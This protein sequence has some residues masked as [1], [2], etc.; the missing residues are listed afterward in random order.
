MAGDGRRCC[1]GAPAGASRDGLR[2]AMSHFDLSML[3]VRAP[4]P[5]NGLVRTQTHRSASCAKRHNFSSHAHRQAPPQDHAAVQALCC[6]DRIRCGSTAGI[7][8]REIWT[9]ITGACLEEQTACCCSALPREPLTMP[10][11]LANKSLKGLSRDGHRSLSIRAPSTCCS[12]PLQR[13]PLTSQV[14]HPPRAALQC[15]PCCRRSTHAP[16]CS[17]CHC[18]SWRSCAAATIEGAAVGAA[19]VLQLRG[20]LL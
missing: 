13:V 5:A 10:L 9:H 6:P 18:L 20:E 12:L 2:H 7:A 11:Y 14:R 17:L 1:A 16:P 4:R 19:L 15:V 8:T 3:V